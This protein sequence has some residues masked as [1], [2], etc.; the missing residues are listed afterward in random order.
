MTAKVKARSATPV[1]MVPA[2]QTRSVSDAI[3]D[4]GAP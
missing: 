1:R 3:R 4:R 2:Y